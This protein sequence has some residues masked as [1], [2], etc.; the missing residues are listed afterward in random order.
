MEDLGV[1]GPGELPEEYD[2]E[3]AKGLAGHA[4][5]NLKIIEQNLPGG[6]VQQYKQIGQELTKWGEPT[7]RWT[8]K[9]RGKGAGAGTGMK[10][11]D[12]NAIAR[13]AGN[14]FGGM[15]DPVSGR[16]SGLKGENAEQKVQAIIER[17][18]NLFKEGALT[19][20]GAVSKAAREAGVEIEKLSDKPKK[21]AKKT[22]TVKD[23]LE[24]QY[25]KR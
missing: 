1:A 7:Q 13:Q 12:E 11:A 2:E 10:A 9:Q 5:E 24:E 19:R 20:S 23:F 8:P 25:G 15:Y 21:P 3:L 18:S 22:K 6:M 14:L 17:A 16:F 4:T